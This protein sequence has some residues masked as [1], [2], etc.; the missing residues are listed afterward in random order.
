MDQIGP[1][2]PNWT[3][4]ANQTEQTQVDHINQIGPNRLKWTESNGPNRTELTKVDRMD[5][6]GPN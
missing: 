6:T 4:L 2:R 3:E 1:N 5:K